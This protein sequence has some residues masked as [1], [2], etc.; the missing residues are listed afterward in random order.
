[1]ELLPL[2]LV[3]VLTKQDILILL[4]KSFLLFLI[5]W[6][7]TAYLQNLFRVEMVVIL[8]HGGFIVVKG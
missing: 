7:E 1:M 2:S 6:N 4:L 5:Q 3:H 8:V